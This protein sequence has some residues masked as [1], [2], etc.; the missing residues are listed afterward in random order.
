MK[1]DNRAWRER[2]KSRIDATSL[3]T[4]FASENTDSET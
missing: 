4:F 2:R 1:G 3:V